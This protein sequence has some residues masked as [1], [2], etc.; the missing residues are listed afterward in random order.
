MSLV[1]AKQDALIVGGMLKLKFVV[2]AVV[3]LA[4]PVGAVPVVPNFSSG[5]LTQTTTSRSVISEAIVSEDFATGWQYTVSGTGV[6]L[7]GA[8]I[9]PAAII[10]T[11]TT[12]ASGITTKWTGLDVNNKPNWTLTQ[13]GGSFQFQ[14][15]YS[16]PGL[17]NRTTITRT[18]ETDTTI[19]SVS[20][21]SQ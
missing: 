11:N 5:Q 10:N 2:L 13:P 12:A 6:S 4:T 20:V 3:A 7:N 17:Q 19:E 14:S 21:F 9:E 8:S 15:S 16:G 18:I 1:F